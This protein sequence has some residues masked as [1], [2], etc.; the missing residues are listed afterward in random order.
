MNTTR[1]NPAIANS[2]TLPDNS[3][4]A[5]KL[6]HYYIE[7]DIERYGYI[8]FWPV[9]F[10]VGVVGN[11]LSIVILLRKSV[12]NN[13]AMFLIFLAVS[14][15]L[16]L[17]TAGLR[18]WIDYVTGSDLGNISTAWCRFLWFILYLSAD[19][20]SWCVAAVSIQRCICVYFPVQAKWVC[21]SKKA[22]LA[23]VS[24]IAIFFAINSP[25][26]FIFELYANPKGQRL[27]QVL[28]QYREF[29]SKVFSWIDFTSVFLVPMALL[30]ITNT[31]IV[32]RL[33]GSENTLG[34]T[35]QN[36][37]AITMTRISVSI[38]VCFFVFGLPI[39]VYLIVEPYVLDHASDHV[40]AEV[41][42]A[43]MIARLVYMCNNSINFILYCV[44]GRRFRQELRTIFRINRAVV[45]PV[46]SNVVNMTASSTLTSRQPP[47]PSNATG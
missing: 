15:T 29:F 28:P 36:S 19:M 2:T 38:S 30:I 23:S 10:L 6:E 39:V 44:T 1:F 13:S 26:L 21:T 34:G 22:L 3:T 42:V 41:K 33:F 14:D 5:N 11:T 37:R 4:S 31:L 20:S 16:V 9:V 27:C 45:E 40:V 24:F 8:I 7:N 47:P 17:G 25:M 18:W 43:F 35:S 12:W 46:A 32:K